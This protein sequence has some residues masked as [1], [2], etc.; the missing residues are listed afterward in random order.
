MYRAKRVM[1]LNTNRG[2]EMSDLLTCKLCFSCTY[3][4]LEV[5]NGS[6]CYMKSLL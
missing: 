1:D 4:L 6:C 5:A 2:V 3:L